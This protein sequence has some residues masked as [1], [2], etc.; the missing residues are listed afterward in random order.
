MRRFLFV[1]VVFLCGSAAAD[2][3]G[4]LIPEDKSLPPLAMLNHKVR[5]TIDDQ[6][7]VTRVEQT[8]RN[9]TDRNLE[10]T[11]IF[12]VPPGASVNRF[13]MWVNGKETKGELVEA[14]KARDIYTSI[15]RRTQDPALLEYMGNNLLRLRVFPI[16]PEADQKVSLQFAS[17]ASKEGKLVEY[18]YPLKTNGK[19]TSTLEEFSLTAT[20][21]SEH[22]VTNVYSPT[23]SVSLKR[24]SDQEV[25]VTFDQNQALLDKDFQLFYATGDKDVGLTALTHRP[26]KGDK[27]FFTLLIAPRLEMSKRYQVPRDLV[28][29]LDTSGSMRGVKMEQARKALKYC[30]DNLGAND[31]FGLINFATTVNRYEDKLLPADTEQL[32]KA[33]KWVEELEATGGTAI[34]DALASALE[35]RGREEGRSFTVVFFTDGQP[36]IGE[37]DMGKIIKNTL[38]KNTTNTRIFTFGVGDDVNASMLDQIAEKTRALST[39]VRPAEDIEN[40]VSGL[41]SKISNPVLTNLKLTA[42]NDIKFSE[43]YPPELPDLFHGGQLVV[44]GRYSGKGAAAVKLSG[45]VGMEQKEFVYELTF[46][47][48][49]GEDREFVEHLWARRKVGYML[50]QIRANGERKELVEE[51]VRL[52]KRYGITTPYTSYLVVPDAAMPVANGGMLGRDGRMHMSYGFAGGM[53]GAG[54]GAMPAGLAPSSAAGKPMPVLDFAKQNQAKPGQLAENRS[55]LVDK[56]LKKVEGAKGAEGEALRRV[57]EKKEAYDRARLFL[58]EKAMDAVQAGKL[59]VDLSV[60]MQNLRGQTRLEQTAVRNVFGRNCLEIG[61]VW[62]DEDFD[63]KMTTVV[64]KAQSDAYFKLLESRP[65]LRDVFKLGNH[66]VWVAPSG[67]ALVIDTS[68]G[69]DKL[70]EDEIAK[71]F[72]AKK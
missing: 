20:I 61:G 35:L 37:T 13:S 6:L 72:A 39:Y 24:G 63:P 15:V 30:L 22:N 7:A 21:K 11:Y 10:A 17:V 27:G 56:D 3:H 51:V 28:L 50:D 65:K 41:Y 16:P 64:V 18:V 58:R 42:T 29:V 66:L 53:M 59:G 31:R 14:N 49:T 57:H 67:T 12:P 46:P 1:V 34:N 62:I 32:A 54:G 70:S 45:W 38:A 8:F 2:A 55:E 47:E 4:L 52:A 48:K 36:T 44:L 26:L 68:T 23:H 9:H 43:V 33:K 5:I 71:L 60:Q 40:K 25:T 69:K 19:A